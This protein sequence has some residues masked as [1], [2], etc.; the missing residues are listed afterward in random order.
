MVGTDARHRIELRD[1][2]SA[3]LR[4]SVLIGDFTESGSYR[5]HRVAIVMLNSLG[6]Q[7]YSGMAS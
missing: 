3:D 1:L 6:E 5:R 4:S 7:S 2:R